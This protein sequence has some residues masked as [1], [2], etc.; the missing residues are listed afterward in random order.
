M[1]KIALG[2]LGAVAL[3]VVG[4]EI[5]TLLVLTVIMVAAAHWLLR[6]AEKRY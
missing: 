2:I 6:E 4:Q 3:Q 1:K 5:V